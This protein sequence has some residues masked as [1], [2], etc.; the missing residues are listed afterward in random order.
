MN[1]PANTPRDTIANTGPHRALVLAVIS[2]VVVATIAFFYYD[3]LTRHHRSNGV[4]RLGARRQI[5]CG[6]LSLG[7]LRFLWLKPRLL[8][9]IN[10]LAS[11]A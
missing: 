4:I 5:Q 7:G 10:P 1:G 8:Q 11:L 3:A 6:F 2:T 9:E